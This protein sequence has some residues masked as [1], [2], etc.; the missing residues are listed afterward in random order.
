MTPID[1]SRDTLLSARVE[2]FEAEL[3]LAAGDVRGAQIK[4]DLVQAYVGETR[5]LL[6]IAQTAKPAT[7]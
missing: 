2:L 3:A 5:K 7:S 6:T 1:Q 4:L